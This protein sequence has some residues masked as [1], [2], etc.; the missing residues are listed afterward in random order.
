M[1]LIDANILLYAKIVE[2]P[3]HEAA[4]T[5]LTKKLTGSGRVG[6]PWPSLLAFHRIA[7]S[8]RVLER[9]VAAAESWRQIEQWLSLP[10][11]WCPVP[12]ERHAA[13]LGELIQSADVQANLTYDAHLAALAIEYG[14]ML[15]STDRD[16]ARFDRL[17]F[18]NPL[19]P[20]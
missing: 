15:C 5:W 14:L 2:Y 10:N 13:I 8:A 18:E 16:F 9:P 19:A 12:T 20:T 7:T 3:Q 1:I 6:L 11:V 17:R 4:R